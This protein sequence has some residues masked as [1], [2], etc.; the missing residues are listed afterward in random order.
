[1]EEEE[2]EEEKE[3]E[4]GRGGHT[5]EE[6]KTHMKLNE[7]IKE[8]KT[9]VYFLKFRPLIIMKKNNIKKT[10]HSSCLPELHSKWPSFPSLSLPSFPS[11]CTFPSVPQ[12]FFV[13]P[14]ML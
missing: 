10:A 12:F 14:L 4:G 9:Q 3:D 8:G 7:F 5:R 1:M 11:G 2:E 13:S 6:E